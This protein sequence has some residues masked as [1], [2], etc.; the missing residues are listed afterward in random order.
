MGNSF[1]NIF[2]QARETKAKMNNWNSIKFKSF[3]S[4]KGT[5]SRTKR[6][7]T[8]WENIFINGLSN[9]G[10]NPKYIK[11]AYTSLPKKNQIV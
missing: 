10:L 5:I 9:K 6:Q 4:A 1:M 3:Y 7:P 8:V 11:N 2:P